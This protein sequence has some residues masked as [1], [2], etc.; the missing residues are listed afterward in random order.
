MPSDKARL[1]QAI[2]TALKGAGQFAS[3][4]TAA[5]ESKAVATWTSIA[6]AI[7]TELTGHMDIQ[8]SSGDIKVDPGSFSTS[9][10]PVAGVG[11]SE[12]ATLTG[13]L[14]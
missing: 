14:K 1:G 5:D 7:L 9:A 3:D 10:G 4:A 8:L 12:G 11:T 2:V 6:G 13:K